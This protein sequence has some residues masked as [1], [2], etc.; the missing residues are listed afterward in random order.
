MPGPTEV[1]ELVG[2]VLLLPF[3]FN[4]GAELSSLVGFNYIDSLVT[5]LQRKKKS[6][7]MA[8]ATMCRE[9]MLG[10][11]RILLLDEAIFG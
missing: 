10:F 4:L 8:M 9:P 3:Y 2:A 11:D 1:R 6:G 5:S 7:L